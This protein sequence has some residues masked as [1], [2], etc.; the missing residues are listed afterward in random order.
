MELTLESCEWSPS[1]AC[2]NSGSNSSTRCTSKAFRL[3]T[4]FGSTADC[5]HLMTG[6]CELIALI[7]CSILA[8]SASSGTR[9]VLFSSTLSAKAICST[10]SFSTPS[11]FSSSR[12]WTMCFASTTVQMPS[13]VYI[14]WMSSSTKKVCAT[15]AGSASPVV[16]IIT[17]SNLAILPCNLLRACTRSPRTVQQMQPFMT[18]IT[19][20]STFS[21]IPMIFS[22]TPTSPNSFSM[23]A[24]RMPWSGDRKM[25]FSNVVLPEPKKPVN[26]VTGTWPLDILASGKGRTW[27][28]NCRDLRT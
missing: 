3:I 15:G 22:S 24:K 26:T 21:V 20:S 10:A 18:S 5:W 2:R 8:S 13:S 11:G 9:S 28:G 16:S 25:W 6:A 19:S 23:M 27:M 12:C 4:H 17:A 7:F 14:L 1:P